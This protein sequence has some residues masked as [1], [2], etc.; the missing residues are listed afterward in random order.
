MRDSSARAEIAGP[1][2]LRLHDLL[3]KKKAQNASK[4]QMIPRRS[5]PGPCP[6]SFAQQRLWFL[7]QL[8]GGSAF[9]N[10]P[11][12]VRLDGP[13]DIVA[14]RRALT[15]VVRRHESLRT[16]FA[17]A[18]GQPVQII[19]PRADVPLPLIDLSGLSAGAREA[20]ASRLSGAEALRAFD[21]TSGPALRATLL[22]L[23][24]QEHAALLTMHHIVS[25]AWSKDILVRE[26]SSLYAAYAEGRE[27][28][29]E[30]LP[31]QYADYAA[32]QRGWLRGEALDRQL[33][34]WKAQLAGAPPVLELPTGRPRPH[35]PSHRGARHSFA[36]SPE[37]SRA[38]KELSRREGATTFMTLLAAFQLLLARYTGQTDIV[39]GSPIAERGR[40]ETEGLIGFFVNT[41]A[42]RTDLSADPSFV[43]LLG[44]A[45][46]TCLGAYA[47]QDVPFEKLVEELQPERSLSHTPLFQVAFVLQTAPRKAADASGLRFISVERRVVQFDLTLSMEERGGRF[48]GSFEY[49]T[50]LF[51]AATVGRMAEHFLVLLAGAVEDPGRRVSR[52]TLLAAEERRRLL[53]EFNDTAREYPR[54]L[55]LH[56]LFEE[57]ARRAP[58]SVA[59]ASDEARLTY[60]ELDARANRLARHL[61]GLGVGPDVR[62]AVMLERS[63]EL[64]VSLLAVL[65]AGGAYVPLDPQYP[66]QRLAYMLED[67]GAAVVL[68]RSALRDALP[69]YPAR[70]VCLDLEGEAIANES[71][72]TLEAG[73]SAENLAYVMYTSGS[74]GAP[75]GVAVTHRNVARLVLSQSYAAFGPL[76]VFLLL[77]PAC[78]DAS[79][80]ELWGALLHGA[81]LAV[82]PPGAHSLQE[83]GRAL[84]R[85]RVTT[86]W[87]TAGLFQQAVE[88]GVEQLAG[89]RQLLTGGDVVSPAAAARYLSNCGGRLVNAY[90]PT[91]TTTFACCQRVERRE[92]SAGPVPIGRP[93]SNTRVYVLDANLEPA[94]V[95]V[96]GELY[97]G[98]DGLA[99]GYLNR[100][101]LTAERFVPD[102][103]SGE[104]GGR[105]YRTGDVVKYLAD[106]RVEFIGRRD[107]Q[108]KV[109]GF[110]VEVGEVEAA[111]SAHPRV[112]E[113]AVAVREGVAGDK[114][115]VA[116]VVA[117]G[118]LGG[119]ELRRYSAGRMPEHMA[120]SAYVFL[121]ELPLTENGK[122]DRKALPEPDA[123]RES[124]GGEYVAPRT[125]AEE[126]LCE[127]WAEVLGLERVGAEDN[128]FDLGGHSLL[129]TQ[130]VSR[131]RQECGVEVPL[132][133]IFE[134][135]TVGQLARA[136]GEARPVAE[137][138]D[139]ITKTEQGSEAD[140]L[141]KL[142]G[143]SEAELDSLLSG[144]LSGTE[145]K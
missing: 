139:G 47:H 145:R 67:S 23:G 85:H 17:S 53:V 29:L 60:A 65:K 30:E 125:P 32:W 5:E 21:L 22:R 37:L 130:V 12:A 86:L 141:T 52:L 131:I 116:Y 136:V 26:L 96:P 106:G 121:D 97:V 66:L 88:A 90:G 138:G 14:F 69:V 68:T 129:A 127:I 6:L 48:C 95:G 42:L 102:T 118:E 81:R 34:Y 100:P 92:A 3:L 89:V 11:L 103:F 126:A 144:M 49:K 56:E 4:G 25:D 33:S 31:I 140:L 119:G 114:R 44:R 7:D 70:E 72:E 57:Q 117:R 54:D 132:V 123:S 78:F 36:L 135:P 9:Y 46:E 84:A 73:A 16:T 1:E 82:M 41:L 74:T 83:L 55:C 142:E 115:L 143:L 35:A 19:S 128:F 124:A 51:D 61:R 99:R 75:K 109:R 28:P 45:R 58:D 137:D 10:I 105:L 64:V 94:P 111:L 39:V 24:A 120:P 79:T 18:D 59:L 40:L 87:L 108:V 98:G 8:E 43:E 110:R 63:F 91:E 93:I 113:C 107:G 62:V 122:V 71:A 50:D 2:R 76:E 104:A 20:E 133:S 101:A 77:A 15:E 112:R 27:S 80:F 38:V 13:F 134:M